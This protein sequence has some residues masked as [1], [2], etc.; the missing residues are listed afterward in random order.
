MYQTK[1]TNFGSKCRRGTDFSTCRT[2]VD[3]LYFIRVLKSEQNVRA[4][5]NPSIEM[6]LTSLG[7]IG[8]DEE[9]EEKLRLKLFGVHDLEFSLLTKEIYFHAT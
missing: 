3:D 4:A 7:A 5:R 9:V 8:D 2:Q 1:R 6:G